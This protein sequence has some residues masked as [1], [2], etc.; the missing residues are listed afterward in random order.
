MKAMRRIVSAV[1]LLL[2]MSSMSYADEW[3]GRRERGNGDAGVAIVAGILGGLAAGVILDRVLTPSPPSPAYYP[4][5]PAS[6]PYDAGYSEGY[7]QGVERGRYER[8][9]Q[10]RRRGYD[11]GYE[12]ARSGR[13]Y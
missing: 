8:Y 1:L 9:D 10:G 13:V 2:M 6:D 12:D 7:G 11:D 3:R 4:P 5:A